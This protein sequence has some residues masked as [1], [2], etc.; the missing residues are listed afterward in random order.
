MIILASAVSIF[1][2]AGSTIARSD[3]GKP[4]VQLEPP[5]L[6]AHDDKQVS[7]D[8]G[9]LL[10]SSKIIIEFGPGQERSKLRDTIPVTSKA[11]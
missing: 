1:L 7:L 2:V 5:K 8:R 4:A 9:E 6:S 3:P 11:S 10:V